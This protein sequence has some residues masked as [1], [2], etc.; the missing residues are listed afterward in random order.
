MDFRQLLSDPELRSEF[1]G[2][3]DEIAASAD[4][5]TGGLEGREGG[6]SA[7]DIEEAAEQMS[8]GRWDSS[9]RGLEAIIRRFVRPVYLVQQ[10]TFSLS[11]GQAPRSR[12]IAARLEKARA[13]LDPVI[14]STGRIDLRNHR[15]D[16]VG[17]GWM[18]APRI[19]VTNR[20]V[21]EEFSR[22]S[23][24]GFAFKHNSGGRRIAAYIDWREEYLQP[25]ESRF[26]VEEIRWIEPDDSV[27]V[28]L[29]CIS[30]VG[31]DGE[32]PP[33][34]VSLMT[35]EDV[36][37]LDVGAWIAVIGYPGYDSR[38]DVSDQQRIFAGIY[39]V[40]RF[41]PGKVTAFAGNELL[42]HDATTLGGSSGSIVVDLASG[43]A[44][45]LHFD[46]LEGEHNTAVLAP[47][48]AH[49][50]SM[51]ANNG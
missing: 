34:A 16:W 18:V 28:A 46:G 10:G 4:A 39:N 50:A 43:K 17:T 42:Y 13:K 45:G 15:L 29:L 7:A 37:H 23:D 12:K 47:R 48:V 9:D 22:A 38:N 35:D 21:A 5:E 11:P 6:L 41:A 19:V 1:L 44:L 33:P 2:R 51:H 27:D 36:K 8:E 49:I 40:K 14:G 26:R 20:H 30:G 31:E 32:I 24:H 25:E 3:I